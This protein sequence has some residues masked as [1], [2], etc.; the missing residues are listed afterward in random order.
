MRLEAATR[1]LPDAQASAA[2]N[3]LGLLDL[4]QIA[5]RGLTAG[6]QYRVYLAQANHSPYGNL[7]PLATFK[8]NPDGRAIVQMV[9]PLLELARIGSDNSEPSPRRFLIVADFDDPP[10]VVLRQASPPTGP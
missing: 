10:R 8:A 6:A 9:G 3:S 7:E 2:I 5:M 1:A 4:V